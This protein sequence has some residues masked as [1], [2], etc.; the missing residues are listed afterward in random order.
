MHWHENSRRFKQPQL[1]EQ[2]GV[3]RQ[4]NIALEAGKYTPS[5]TLALKITRTF[6]VSVEDMFQFD[7]Q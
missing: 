1:A 6:S 7:D 3:T 5:L 4:T 2:M